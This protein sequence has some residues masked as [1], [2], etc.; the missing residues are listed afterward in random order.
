MINYLL[1]NAVNE[2]CFS[3]V[4]I[5]IFLAFQFEIT[6]QIDIDR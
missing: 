6:E 5:S 1:L 4:M 2:C 3:Y